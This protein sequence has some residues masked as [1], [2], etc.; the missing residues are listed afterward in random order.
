MNSL[1]ELLTKS[2]LNLT[3]LIK[4]VIVILN[5]QTFLFLSISVTKIGGT[6]KYRIPAYQIRIY[7]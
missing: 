2:K 1:D 7:Q 6:P 3:Q 4:P 5:K